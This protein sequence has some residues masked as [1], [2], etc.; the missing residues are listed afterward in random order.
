MNNRL[1]VLVVSVS[2][3]VSGITKL[4]YPYKAVIFVVEHGVLP[5]DIVPILLSI[6]VIFSLCLGLCIIIGRR[7]ESY[8]VYEQA[9]IFI[10]LSLIYLIWVIIQNGWSGN[11]GCFPGLY[12]DEPMHISLIRDSILLLIMLKLYCDTKSKN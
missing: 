11:C 5:V 12:D 1:A 10:L 7:C 8:Y 2:L 9:L 6:H 4:I 3:I